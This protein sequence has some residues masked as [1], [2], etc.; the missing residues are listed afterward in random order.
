[1]RYPK[2]TPPSKAPTSNRPVKIAIAEPR[3]ALRTRVTTNP[4]NPA[5]DGAPLPFDFSGGGAFDVDPITDPLSE[6][7]GMGLWQAEDITADFYLGGTVNGFSGIIYVPG[8]ELDIAGSTTLDGVQ[9]VAKSFN[10]RGNTSVTLNY[11]PWFEFDV[12]QVFLVE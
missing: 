9:V 4:N 12:P 6:Y 8:A 7:Y 11:N 10:V 1:M 2:L 3:S 5:G